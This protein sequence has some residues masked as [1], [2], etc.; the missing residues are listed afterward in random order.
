V[1]EVESTDNRAAIGPESKLVLRTLHMSREGDE[2]LIGDV[3]RG[4]FV[5]VPDIAVAVVMALRDGET[6][7]GTAQRILTE[8]GEQV[9]VADFVG[10][11]IDFGFVAEIDGKAI[12]G[13]E[14]EFSCGGRAGARA[15]ARVIRPL[16]S[17]PA[18]VLYGV[19]FVA[20]LVA[21]TAVPNLRPHLTQLFF[22]PNP[23]V[24][25]ALLTAIFAALGMTHELAHWAGALIKGMPARITVSRRYYMLVLQTDLSALW[26]LPRRQRFPPL[27]AGIAWDTVR[28]SALLGARAAQLEGWWH[29]GSVGTRLIAALI[30]GHVLI[31]SLQ[32][33]VFLRTDIYAVLVIGI[34][35]LNLTRISKLLMA[36]RYRALTADEA[37]EL[38][39][40]SPRDLA[41]ARWYGWVQAGGV[42]V[43]C[44]YFVGFFVPLLALVVRWV[45]D[46]ISR[47]PVSAAGFWETLA[48]GLV[49][50]TPAVLPPVTYM[51]DRRRQTIR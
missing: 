41:A 28:L 33:L 6:I 7:A 19:L 22:L 4:E 51:R 48:S 42:A 49:A 16:Y 9:D 31:I 2:Y 45:F 43:V 47:N 13:G 30:V 15:I 10:T 40:A 26:A 38:D 20:C 27:L 37:A 18:F 25:I 50:L 46:G 3:A 23:V 32:F 17:L 12:G 1:L 5:C 44:A 14:S 21:L 29:P 39:S 8:T 11:L 24:S 34:G 35:C 36:R